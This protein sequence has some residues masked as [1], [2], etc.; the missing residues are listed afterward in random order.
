VSDGASDQG[1]A[2]PPPPSVTGTSTMRIVVGAILMAVLSLVFGGAVSGWGWPFWVNFATQTLAF[3]LAG[4]VAARVARAKAGLAAAI[5][6]GLLWGPILLAVNSRVPTRDHL[7]VAT[8]V[9]AAILTAHVFG[10][11]RARQVKRPDSSN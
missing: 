1:V 6:L 9:F 4:W 10:R 11:R 8:Y 2:I 7:A 3:A 5:G